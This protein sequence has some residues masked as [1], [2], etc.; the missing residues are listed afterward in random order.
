MKHHASL[1]Q[2]SALCNAYS[3]I[4]QFFLLQPNTDGPEN[5][6]CGG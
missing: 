5:I 4:K 6:D 3:M 2:D 1:I